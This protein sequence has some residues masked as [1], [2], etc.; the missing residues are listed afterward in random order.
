MSRKI[1]LLW[2]PMFTALVA[3][4]AL[5]AAYRGDV[6]PPMEWAAKLIATAMTATWIVS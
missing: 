2:L 3:G 4:L 6:Q 5:C 1:I